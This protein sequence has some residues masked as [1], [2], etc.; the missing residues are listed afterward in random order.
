MDLHKARGVFLRIIKTLL[1]IEGGEGSELFN[2]TL[3]IFIQVICQGKLIL[4]F[5]ATNF[6]NAH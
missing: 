1:F 4:L 2:R 5:L 6:T 3:M